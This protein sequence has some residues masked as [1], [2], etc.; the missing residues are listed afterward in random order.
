MSGFPNSLT[1]Y[2]L[3]TCIPCMSRRNQSKSNRIKPN[4]TKSN[5]YFFKQRVPTAKGIPRLSYSTWDGNDG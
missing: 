2:S 5:H 3:S 1:A 4:P